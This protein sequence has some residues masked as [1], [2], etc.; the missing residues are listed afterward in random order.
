MGSAE[1]T[2]DRLR[3]FVPTM[4][5]ELEVAVRARILAVH[6]L[7]GGCTL[8]AGEPWTPRPRTVVHESMDMNALEEL[9]MNT[10]CEA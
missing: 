8:N 10:S 3:A 6:S 1:V 9:I 5:E 4:P 7:G 2:S